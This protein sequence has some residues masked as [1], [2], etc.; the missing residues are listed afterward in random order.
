M[1]KAS[2]ALKILTANNV[3]VTEMLFNI[4]LAKLRL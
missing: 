4:Y 1:Q 3:K 2:G